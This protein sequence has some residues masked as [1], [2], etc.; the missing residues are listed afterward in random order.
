MA[1]GC[2]DILAWMSPL[3]CVVLSLSLY[4]ILQLSSAAASS[5]PV[6]THFS[7]SISQEVAGGMPKVPQERATAS[8]GDHGTGLRGTLLTLLLLLL[9]MLL[10]LA[11]GF[12]M[13]CLLMMLGCDW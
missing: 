7:S 8:A 1:Q 4:D 3:L 11:A 6:I 10:L 12:G 5:V 9:F 2:M 13:S